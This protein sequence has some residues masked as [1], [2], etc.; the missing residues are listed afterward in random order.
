M[1]KLSEATLNFYHALLLDGKPVLDEAGRVQQVETHSIKD[2]ERMSTRVPA[3][4]KFEM[5]DTDANGRPVF[6][7]SAQSTALQSQLETIKAK[8]GWDGGITL[9]QSRRDGSVFVNLYK[10]TRGFKLADILG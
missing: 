1:F 4:S 5:F 10:T 3:V 8:L 7:A 9:N 2:A 6:S